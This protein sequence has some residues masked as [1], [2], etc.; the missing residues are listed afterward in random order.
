MHKDL[1]DSSILVWLLISMA[2]GNRLTGL[3]LSQIRTELDRLHTIL[4]TAYTYDPKTKKWGKYAKNGMRI[5]GATLGAL[6]V[7]SSAQAG[8]Q[9]VGNIINYARP[10]QDSLRDEYVNKAAAD[11][12][13]LN[14][15]AV[16][17]TAFMALWKKVAEA[18]GVIEAEIRKLEKQLKDHEKSKVMSSYDIP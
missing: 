1:L 4:Q 3:Q 10:G 8:E 2:Q 9:F 5:G 15:H 12:A 13:G 18:R 6:G 16:A 14:S 11:A 7:I 17:H